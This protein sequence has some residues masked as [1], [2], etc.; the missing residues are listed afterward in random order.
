MYDSNKL[1]SQ[2]NSDV[3]RLRRSREEAAAVCKDSKDVLRWLVYLTDN[4]KWKEALARAR[5]LSAEELKREMAFDTGS[6]NALH[7]VCKLGRDEEAIA[8][9]KLLV[10]HGANVNQVVRKVTPLYVAAQ[11]KRVEVVREL[12][13][14]AGIEESINMLVPANLVSPLCVA[15]QSGSREVVELLLKNP[16]IDVNALSYND[17]VKA[18]TTC[19]KA[20]KFAMENGH[21]DIAR[22]LEAHG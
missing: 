11:N 2:M 13:K 3:A 15:A 19:K 18:G 22:M 21:K 1:I 7:H 17:A 16:A 8:L 12:L 20:V 9:L 5:E 10:D 4:E 14:C 6:G